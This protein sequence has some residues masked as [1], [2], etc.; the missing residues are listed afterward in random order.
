MSAEKPRYRW[1]WTF[2]VWILL[3][4]FAHL[5]LPLWVKP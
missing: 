3:P 1:S 5:E 2:E 4:A